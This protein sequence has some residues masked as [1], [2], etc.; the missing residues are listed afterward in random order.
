MFLI[1]LTCHDIS[2]EVDEDFL[3]FVARVTLQNQQAYS[4]EIEIVL[5][6]DAAIHELNREHLGHDYP[7]DVISFLYE[8][9]LVREP[10][11]GAPRGAGKHIAGELFLSVDTAEREAL[12]FGWSLRDELA[13][14]VVHGLLHL[15]GYDDLT[16]AEKPLM[17]Q[18]EAEMLKHVGLSPRYAA[19]DLE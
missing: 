3:E 17:R 11:P 14:Y 8:D 13:L 5:L 6:S 9:A 10:L 16:A 1:D 4:A 2:Q 18:Q 15:C 7:T 19:D 12:E